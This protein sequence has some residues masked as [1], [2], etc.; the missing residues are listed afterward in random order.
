[1]STDTKV[2]ITGIGAITPVGN[3]VA[4]MWES[5]RNGKAVNEGRQVAESTMTGILGRMSAYT[6]RAITWDWAMNASKLD[7]TPPAYKFGDLPMP[8]VAIPGQTRL[9]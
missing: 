7:L 4:E 3:S 6:G 9:I 2:L 8:P 5:I 1:M